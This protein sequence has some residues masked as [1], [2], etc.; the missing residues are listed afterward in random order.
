MVAF[1]K[2]VIAPVKVATKVPATRPA[3][4]VRVYRTGGAALNRV[5]DQPQ[6]TVDA[7]AAN[8]VDAFELAAKCREA[9]LNNASQMQL[10]RGA[11]EVGGLHL[12]PDPGTNTPRYRF[13]VGLSVRAG[14]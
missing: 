11:T 4:F 9:L 2:P 10:V 5:L 1:L 6:I 3:S 8:E 13:T 12:N 14:R 7:W